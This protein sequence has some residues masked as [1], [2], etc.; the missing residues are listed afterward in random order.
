MVSI[1]A[2]TRLDSDAVRQIHLAAFPESENLIVSSLAVNL[3]AEE[4]APETISLI[5]EV[6]GTAAGHIAFSPVTSDKDKRWSGYI[7]SP[8]AVK[9]DYQ[10]RQ[11]GS[12]LIETGMAQLSK[13]GV[14]ALFVYGDPEYYGLFGFDADK[15]APY[16]APY[17][18][19]FPFGWQVII[20][21]DYPLVEP[22]VRL[23]CV[24]SLSDPALW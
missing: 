14:N 21:N 17:E 20:L 5:A 10:K 4:S 8:L 3:L 11:I 9:P 16:L 2:A 12:K 13:M 15:A 19:E 6:D 18:L 1:R 22:S 24:E 7:L 23:S